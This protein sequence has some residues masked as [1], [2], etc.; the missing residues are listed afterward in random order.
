MGWDGLFDRVYHDKIDGVAITLVDVTH[1]YSVCAFHS[2][3]EIT[4]KLGHGHLV[5][6][7][8]F[9]D[10][11]EMTLLVY[12][13]LAGGNLREHLYGTR[14][15]PLNWIQRMEI[16]IGVARGLCYLHGLQLTHGAVRTSNILLD[17]ECR[18]KITNLALPPN[19]LDNQA[20]EVR[21][22]DGY[23]DPEYLHTG[24]RT[25]KSDVYCFGLARSP[26]WSPCYQ[27]PTS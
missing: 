2:L 22:T 10:D 24:L 23:I 11:Q 26:L 3:I 13:Y 19:L 27:A 18:A 9:C 15:P 6:L 7:I 16:C 5:P 1:V 14:K 8:G 20:T 25:E 12:E 4:S 17:E 21:E